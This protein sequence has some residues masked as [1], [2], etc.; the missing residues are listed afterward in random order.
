[1][2]C[3]LFFLLLLMQTKSKTQHWCRQRERKR[4]REKHYFDWFWYKYCCVFLLSI[5]WNAFASFCK[6]DFNARCDCYVY[7]LCVTMFHG[8][9]VSEWMNARR[10]LNRIMTHIWMVG[11]LV[12]LNAYKRTQEKG[13]EDNKAA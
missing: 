3:L 8:E 10:W 12:G 2:W 5:R 11:W 7:I 6:S 1:M 13:K 4:K 9:W